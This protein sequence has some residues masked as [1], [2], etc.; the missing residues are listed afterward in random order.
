MDAYKQTPKALEKE[1]EKRFIKLYLYSVSVL[2]KCV[3]QLSLHHS[4]PII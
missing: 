4:L 1:L 3:C 2:A